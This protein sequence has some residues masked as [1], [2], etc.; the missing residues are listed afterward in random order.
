MGGG[1]EIKMSYTTPSQLELD[2]L[3]GNDIGEAQGYKKNYITDPNGQSAVQ[4]LNTYGA[5]VATA[6][7]GATPSGLEEVPTERFVQT[8]EM[9][10]ENGRTEAEGSQKNASRTVVITENGTRLNLNYDFSPQRVSAEVCPDS[11]VCDQAVYDLLIT[12]RNDRGQLLWNK[13]VRIGN[14]NSTLECTATPAF[15]RDT[16]LTLN[17]GTYTIEKTLTLN[18]ANQDRYIAA[19]IGAARACIERD[20]RVKIEPI[21]CYPDQC[22]PCQFE[23]NGNL[24]QRKPG[25]TVGC[26]RGCTLNETGSVWNHLAYEALMRDMMPGGQYAEL[27]TDLGSGERGIDASRHPLSIFNTSSTRRLGRYISAVT[28][29]TDLQFTYRLPAYDYRNADGSIAE[30]DATE[31]EEGLDYVAGVGRTSAG[32]IYI[33]PEHVLNLEKLETLW[34]ESWSESLVPYHPEYAFYLYSYQNSS[35]TIYDSTL[36]RADF[37]TASREGYWK[38]S[39]GPIT[40]TDLSRDPFFTGVDRA[41]LRRRMIDSL[42]MVSRGPTSLNVYQMIRLA[43]KCNSPY[44]ETR[45]SEQ[46][47]CY[48]IGM[49]SDFTDAEKEF[50]W[51]TFRSVYIAKKQV[52]MDEEFTTRN[53]TESALQA[54]IDSETYRCPSCATIDLHDLFLHKHRRNQRSKCFA[55][56]VIPSFDT[57]GDGTIEAHEARLRSTSALSDYHKKYLQQFCGIDTV[58]RDWMYFFSALGMTNQLLSTDLIIPAT[59]GVFLSEAM[60]RQFPNRSAINYRYKAI[61]TANQLHIRISDASG[62]EQAS[63]KLKNNGFRHHSLVQNQILH[64]HTMCRQYLYTYGL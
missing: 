42:N 54:C 55:S 26:Q 22:I 10:H 33:H 13:G 24:L 28:A 59:P 27:Y 25:N 36:M 39:G 44:Y 3:F 17:T 7:A 34:Q 60:I 29:S 32:H 19:A 30:I 52:L 50:A 38:E 2:R 46:A 21:P 18:E 53:A 57:N 47:T 51:S 20:V 14:L 40:A 45:P 4:Y 35:S 5:V 1:H 15:S 12:V 11:T 61:V 62:A 48:G 43:T 23:W 31:W 16:F 41:D 8:A 64:L 58:A 9:V 6:L 63:L 49:L 37:V 56:G